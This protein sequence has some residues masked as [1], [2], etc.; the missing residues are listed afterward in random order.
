M[1]RIA[2]FNGVEAEANAQGRRGRIIGMRESLGVAN[3][4]SQAQ[5]GV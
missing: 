1:K 2:I 4:D 5:L 3:N